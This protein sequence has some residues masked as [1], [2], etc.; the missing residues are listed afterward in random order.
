[1]TAHMNTIERERKFLALSR[2]I[3][4]ERCQPTNEGAV[5]GHDVRRRPNKIR[6]E[7]RADVGRHLLGK[8]L[9]DD[10]GPL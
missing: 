9:V 5:L 10:G 1:M 7:G 6:R 8:E 2:W 3:S 4:D